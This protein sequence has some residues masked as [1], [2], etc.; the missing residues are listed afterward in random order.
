VTSKGDRIKLLFTSDPYTRLKPGA[1]GTFSF[2]DGIGT[3]HVNWDS[4]STLGLIPG[5]DDWEIAPP[6]ISQEITKN[7]LQR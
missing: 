3:V 6:T 5:E 1:M 2:I 7:S 4:G